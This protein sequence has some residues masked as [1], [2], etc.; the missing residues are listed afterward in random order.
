MSKSISATHPAVVLRS[1]YRN[2]RSL[3]AVAL[4]AI[5]GLST[6]VVVLAVDGDGTATTTSQV[7]SV[8][9]SY[10][11]LADPFQSHSEQ[12]RSD[13]A[14]PDESAVAAAIAT[15]PPVS[16]PDESKVAATIG[17][18]AESGPIAR[19]RAYTKE[20]G[21]MMPAQLKAA[22]STGR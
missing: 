20:I 21:E 16:G 7:Q 2:L 1:H 4:V 13:Q 9:R 14:R 19:D 11:T 3:F 10:P 22:F 12:P 5:V 18:Q 6:A 15:K 8:E 17:S